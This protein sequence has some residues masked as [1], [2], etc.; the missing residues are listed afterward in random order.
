[1][2]LYGDAAEILLVGSEGND[3]F[4]LIFQ[5]DMVLLDLRDSGRLTISRQ[6]EILD[7]L[8][9]LLQEEEYPQ[10]SLSF[11][12]KI[13]F[14]LGNR[15]DNLLIPSGVDVVTSIDSKAVSIS[16]IQVTGDIKYCETET[17]TEIDRDFL[18]QAHQ[19]AVKLYMKRWRNNVA[20]TGDK[21]RIILDWLSCL[22]AYSSLTGLAVY[23]AGLT[24]GDTGYLV[25]SLIPIAFTGL[26]TITKKLL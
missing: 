7:E 5:D 4:R 9:A 16:R 17:T 22:Q 3:D 15:K 1:M 10:D 25:F 26:F 13:K 6:R 20:Q 21:V 19:T 23:L 24:T 12:E 2:I 14:I 8:G 18:S 11:S